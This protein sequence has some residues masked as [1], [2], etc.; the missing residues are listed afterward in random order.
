ME[1]YFEERIS[2][3]KCLETIISNSLKESHPYKVSKNS[4]AV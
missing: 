1:Y 3:L 2:I 4:V